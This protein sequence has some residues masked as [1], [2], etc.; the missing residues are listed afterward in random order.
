MFECV[1]KYR[2]Q[3][4][5]LVNFPKSIDLNGA[6][7]QG[8]FVHFMWVGEHLCYNP[9]LFTICR[10]SYVSPPSKNANEQTA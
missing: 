4:K 1:S 8:W 2:K 9:V 3:V 10:T 6:V 7:A 5:L